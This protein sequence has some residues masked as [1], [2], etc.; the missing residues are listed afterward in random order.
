MRVPPTTPHEVA[1]L[2]LLHKAL[3]ILE[4]LRAQR[5]VRR[6]PQRAVKQWCDDHVDVAGII[7]GSE[8]NAPHDLFVIVVFR[9]GRFAEVFSMPRSLPVADKKG[10]SSLKSYDIDLGW[11]FLKAECRQKCLEDIE[12]YKPKCV[13]VCPP[14]GPFPTRQHCSSSKQDDIAMRR[15]MIEARVLLQFAMQV[16]EVQHREGRLFIFEQLV[17]SSSW[18]EPCVEHVRL[19]DGVHEV[20]LDQCCYGLKDPVNHK[21]YKKRTRLMTDCE[22]M[23]SLAGDCPGDHD[24]L[25]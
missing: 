13:V 19:L 8:G 1:A 3:E 7:D 6:C 20:V 17:G 4:E 24:R 16:C 12:K 5:W 11:D 21:L 9:G 15:K 10:L 18:R 23:K 22:E 25:R 2:N 14:C